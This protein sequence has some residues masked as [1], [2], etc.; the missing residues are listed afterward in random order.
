LTGSRIFTL[1]DTTASYHGHDGIRV[2]LAEMAQ[3]MAMAHQLEEIAD[4][5]GPYF[6]ALTMVRSVANFSRIEF[7]DEVSQVYDARG[8]TIRHQWTL[9]GWDAGIEKLAEIASS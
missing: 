3:S 9:D 5:G 8:G 2:I 1:G 6:A 7:S 4:A